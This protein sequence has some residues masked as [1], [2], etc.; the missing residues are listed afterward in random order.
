MEFLKFDQI[1]NQVYADLRPEKE[2]V[3][4]LN[5][6]TSFEL[7]D[8]LTSGSLNPSK[9]SRAFPGGTSFSPNYVYVSSFQDE[10]R[11]PEVVRYLAFPNLPARKD[12]EALESCYTFQTRKLYEIDGYG[13]ELFSFEG[14]KSGRKPNLDSSF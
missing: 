1:Q 8:N 4:L 6:L 10:T 7:P 2:T 3:I 12:L 9:F 11:K 5:E 13:L 14:L